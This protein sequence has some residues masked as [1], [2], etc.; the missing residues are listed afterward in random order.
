M[1]YKYDKKNL[2]FVE[3][4]WTGICVKA[5]FGALG[6]LLLLATLTE[7]DKKIT[8]REILIITAKNNEFSEEKLMDKIRELKFP[9]PHIV[10]AQA[11][12][13]TNKFS[14]SVFKENNNCFGMRISSQRLSTAKGIQNTYAVY[15]NWQESLLDYAFYYSYYLSKLQTEE[16][17]YNYLQ[18]NYAEDVNYVAKL[19]FIVQK[20]K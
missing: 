5:V 6:F 10:Y 13:E 3:Y 12:L 11:Y 2:K 4:P 14:S 9:F 17:Y 15:T 8:E 18:Q 19:Q 20:L 16:E 7:I 1:L